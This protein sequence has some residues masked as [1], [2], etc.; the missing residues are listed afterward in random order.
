MKDVHKMYI[1]EEGRLWSGRLV[2]SIEETDPS[3]GVFLASCFR[4][5]KM[6]KQLHK[7]IFT[8]LKKS[9]CLLFQALKSK[10][11]PF[12]NVINYAKKVN[13]KSVD[14][15]LCYCKSPA[16]ATCSTIGAHHRLTA[17]IIHIF[18]FDI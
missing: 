3:G 12:R 6:M 5:V 1:K 8:K 10:I 2:S 7:P 15:K 18:T 13:Y 11:Y 14:L 9:I 17:L 16:G 4:I